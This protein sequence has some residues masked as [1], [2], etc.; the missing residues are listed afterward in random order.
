MTNQERL[1]LLAAAQTE[2][3]AAQTELATYRSRLNAYNA[4][5]AARPTPTASSG[6]GWVDVQN[7]NDAAREKS[8]RVLPGLR[9]DYDRASRRVAAA[10]AAVA[11]WSAP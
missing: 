9:E 5:E 4:A 10:L 1:E 7:V 2:L 3:A 8:S 6:P 11:R